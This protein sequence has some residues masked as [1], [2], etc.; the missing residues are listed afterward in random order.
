M[1]KKDGTLNGVTLTVHKTR[2][3]HFSVYDILG[4]CMSKAVGTI[5]RQAT[6]EKFYLPLLA[7]YAQWCA[8]TREPLSNN[9]HMVAISWFGNA[10]ILGSTIPDE[11]AKAAVQDEKRALLNTTKSLSPLPPPTDRQSFGHCA[12]TNQYLIYVRL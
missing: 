11:S 6:R 1:T 2:I 3:P 9:I 12:E 5:P 4:W 7:L 10:L 8:I